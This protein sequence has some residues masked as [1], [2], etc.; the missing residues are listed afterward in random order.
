MLKNLF[1]FVLGIICCA[2]IEAQYWYQTQLPSVFQTENTAIKFIDIVNPNT[3]WVTAASEESNDNS[4]LS[5][6]KTSNT[7]NTWESK[8]FSEDPVYWGI[9]HFDAINENHAWTLMF[10]K[11]GLGAKC[12]RTLNGGQDWEHHCPYGTQSFPNII[13]FFDDQNGVTM[14]DP[15]NNYFEIYTTNDQGQQWN[16][17]TNANMPPKQNNEYGLTGS[18]SAYKDTI[19]FGTTESRILK[20]NDRGLS[21]TAIDLSNIIGPHQYITHLALENGHI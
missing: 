1:C 18:M 14:G 7:G 11:Y 16:A 3:I 17:V 4:P 8:S 12:Y 2:K 9:A 19:W 10:N 6:A 20:S 15:I 13:H 5:Y 21:W